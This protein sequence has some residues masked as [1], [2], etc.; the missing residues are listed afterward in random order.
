M[1]ALS[2]VGIASL[3]VPM[4]DFCG[5]FASRVFRMSGTT[6]PASVVLLLLLALGVTSLVMTFWRTRHSL[7]AVGGLG[8]VAS[9]ALLAMAWLAVEIGDPNIDGIWN[10]WNASPT[11]W[12]ML[13]IITA[14]ALL[15]LSVIMLVTSGKSTVR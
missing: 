15:A 12:I 3:Y 2:L 7:V 1:T 8:V 9:L 13:P 10:C 5:R 11:P 6:G 4:V 14:S